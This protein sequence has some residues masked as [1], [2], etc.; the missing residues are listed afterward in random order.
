MTTGRHAHFSIDKYLKAYHKAEVVFR[1]N[2]PGKE[3]Y[4]IY[5]GKVDLVVQSGQSDTKLATLGPG[6]FFG[7]MALIDDSPR[8]AAAVAAEDDT[9]IIVLDKGKL[10]E[11]LSQQPEIGVIMME[12]LCRRL[13]TTNEALAR[14]KKEGLGS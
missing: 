9:R 12:T 2:T 1:Q 5:S 13:R 14:L 6:E 7:E 4:I 10:V 11:L 3:M 8:S